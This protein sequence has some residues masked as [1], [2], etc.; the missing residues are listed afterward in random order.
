MRRPAKFQHV[1]PYPPSKPAPRA[2]FQY[3]NAG[4]WARGKPENWQSIADLHG[5][6]KVWNLIFYNFQCRN[7]EEVNW[8]MREFLRCTKSKDGSNYSFDPSDINPV[9]YIPPVGFEAFSLDDD[10]ARALVLAVLH[11]PELAA[12]NF[13]TSSGMSVDPG[14]FKKVRHHINTQT[15]LC[16][17]SPTGGA[18]GTL[19]EWLGKQNVMFV[20]DP[21]SRTLQKEAT[22]VHESVHAGHDVRGA[23]TLILE[24]EVCAFIAEAIFAML[25]RKILLTTFDPFDPTQR[26]N[27]IQRWA[28][29]IGKQVIAHGQIS[30]SPFAVRSIDGALTQLRTAITSNPIY[31]EQ[32]GKPQIADGV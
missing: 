31:R 32:A 28:A 11:R 9:I 6:P 30:P 1:I 24:G 20:R 8:C 15:I 7:P 18:A 12:I 26:L 17:G 19:G 25:A 21:K 29:Y 16:A 4:A 23:S 27:L 3:A 22:I 2:I 14:L 13:T 10:A 5:I